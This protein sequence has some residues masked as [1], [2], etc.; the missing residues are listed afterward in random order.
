MIFLFLNFSFYLLY[1]YSIL[2][3]WIEKIYGVLK[4]K[5]VLYKIYNIS[6]IVEDLCI[7]FIC[8]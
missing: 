4:V 6:C 7:M 2:Y 1:V 5:L 3:V 8:I